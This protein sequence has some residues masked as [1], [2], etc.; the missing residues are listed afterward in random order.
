[1]RPISLS[2]GTISC[3]VTDSEQRPIF[4]RRFVLYTRTALVQLSVHQSREV[5]YAET[6]Q[7]VQM[8]IT[9]KELQF[10]TPQL[11]LS[12]IAILQNYRWDNA[13]KNVKPQFIL[14]NELVYKYDRETSSKEGTNICI[15][16]TEICVLLPLESM[17]PVGRGT[18]ISVSSLP[19]CHEQAFPT[20]TTPI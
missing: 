8:K 6:R 9:S 4:T 17:L 19:K 15:L 14:G 13:I 3:T 11:P 5:K 12:K 2:Q 20:P 10:Q 16:R 1:M 18:T 7:S